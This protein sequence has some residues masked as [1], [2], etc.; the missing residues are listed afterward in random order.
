M[1]T[2]E[3]IKGEAFELLTKPSYMNKQ[4]TKQLLMDAL[5][6]AL[7][8]HIGEEIVLDDDLVVEVIPSAKQ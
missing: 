2:I 1:Q 8:R 7:Q 5:E 4:I 6:E 3:E